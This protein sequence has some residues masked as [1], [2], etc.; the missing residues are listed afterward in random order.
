MFGIHAGARINE[1]VTFFGGIDN[2]LDKN[3]RVHGSGVQEPGFNAILGVEM[4]F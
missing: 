3:Y 4:R 2:I 1:C